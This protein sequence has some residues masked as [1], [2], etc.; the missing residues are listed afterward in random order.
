M[1]ACLSIHHF[2]HLP[3]VLCGARVRVCGTVPKLCGALL[4]LCDVGL[5]ACALRCSVYVG[6]M[7]R[8]GIS[9]SVSCGEWARGAHALHACMR[10][11]RGAAERA[12]A[13]W[14]SFGVTDKLGKATLRR[15]HAY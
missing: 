13:P 2:N 9:N 10:A 6:N 4:F 15:M 14:P 8:A 7:P 3:F 1:R 5:V 12:K 11:G